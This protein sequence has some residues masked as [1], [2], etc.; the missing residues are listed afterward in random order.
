MLDLTKGTLNCW[1][2]GGLDLFEGLKEYT[3][4]LEEQIDR[5]AETERHRLAEVPPDDEPEASERWHRHWLFEDAIP[6]NFRYSGVT[7][8][9]T[10]IETILLQ[11]CQELRT[12]R[13][14]PLA[15]SDLHGRT[16][17]RALKYLQKVAGIQLP[18]S[19][20]R[21]TLKHLVTVR[22]CI[23][24]AAG[25]VNLMGSPEAVRVAVAGLDG[26]NLSSDD[27]V[28]IDKGVC[29]RLVDEASRWLDEVVEAT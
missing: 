19:T 15:V 29:N 22:H 7:L 25:N 28:E 3:G 27:Y 8:L 18:A 16:H 14:L 13:K 12:S 1:V 26:F 4:R 6:R 5:M 21:S 9:V 17:E 11:V 20:F 10:T 23:A 24:H 2:F